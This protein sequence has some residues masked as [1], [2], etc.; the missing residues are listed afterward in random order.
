LCAGWRGDRIAPV[1]EENQ[2][3][4]TVGFVGL[5]LMGQPMARHL[6]RSGFRTR[7]YNRTRARAEALS[8]AGALV[9]G[10]PAEAAEGA[11]CVITMVGDV[12]AL[13]EVVW[14]D[15]GVLR[16]LGRGSVL[17]QMATVSR[18][19]VRR[20]ADACALR[21]AE[22]LDAPVTGGRVGA[23][24]GALTVMAGG[25]ERT[26]D[27]VRPILAS[28]SRVVVHVGPVG[29]GT[30]VK[31]A[32]NVIQAGMVE[33]LA[34]SL[35]LVRRAG[36][37]AEA[38]LGV[39]EASAGNSPLLRLKGAALSAG[40]YEP[41]FA[42]K[43]MDKDLRLAA[44]EAKGLGAALPVATAVA[45]F[46]SAAAGRGYGEEDYA[47]VAKLIEELNDVRLRG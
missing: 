21:G 18:E 15:A 24:Q 12:Q 17:L 43:W 47:A 36:L 26:L 10:S 22:L 9:C 16:T 25:D 44:A 3:P 2:L 14:G 4:E 5:G 40:N 27:R 42:L 46:Y 19:Q 41:Q 20:A 6:A 39:L 30:L 31:L 8:A 45:A 35:A 29:A 33:M 23:E 28:F 32:I 13:E 38:L 37:R 11:E 34:E 1:P 7:V